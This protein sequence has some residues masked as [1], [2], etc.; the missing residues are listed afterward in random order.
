M[1]VRSVNK[2]IGKKLLGSMLELG[3]EK[4]SSNVIE[5]VIFV[6]ITSISA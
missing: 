2:V 6:S 4:F 5:K 3:K 1:D